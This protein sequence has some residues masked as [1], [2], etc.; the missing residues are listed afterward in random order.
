MPKETKDW[1][2]VGFGAG[3]ARSP[4]HQLG[5]WGARTAPQLDFR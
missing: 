2:V 5:A 3:V 4:T 1:E